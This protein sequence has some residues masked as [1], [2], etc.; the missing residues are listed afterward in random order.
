MDMLLGR[1]AFG[2]TLQWGGAHGKLWTENRDFSPSTAGHIEGPLLSA[3][4]IHSL[5]WYVVVSCVG[6]A[7]WVCKYVLCVG[8]SGTIFLYYTQ[9]RMCFCTFFSF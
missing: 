4:K 2:G 8:P 7:I 1:K 6:P 3:L 9:I 5:Y